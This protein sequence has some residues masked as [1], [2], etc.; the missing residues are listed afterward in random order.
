MLCYILCH[1]IS[2]RTNLYIYTLIRDWENS[3]GSRTAVVV[4][5]EYSRAYGT[6]ELYMRSQIFL[7]NFYSYKHI[8]AQIDAT[9]TQADALHEWLKLFHYN[10]ERLQYIYRKCFHLVS[11]RWTKKGLLCSQQQPIFH[12]TPCTL[13]IPRAH[14]QT[15]LQYS[16]QTHEHVMMKIV[17]QN[18]KIKCR[19]INVLHPH[20]GKP[21]TTHSHDTA[22]G[23]S[24]RWWRK[25]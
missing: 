10:V 24:K 14:T 22:T 20:R 19:K 5:A 23:G 9:S 15:P 1:T 11:D 8:Y 25:I 21:P 13:Y 7:Y 16:Q 18:W 12:N 17:H 4:I 2:S 6:R 3:F